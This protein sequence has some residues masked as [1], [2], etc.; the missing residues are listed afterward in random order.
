[1][2]DLCGREIDYVRVSITDRCNL[3]CV[4]CMPEK[5]VDAMRHGDMLT[6]EEIVR[7]VRSLASLGI[8]HVRVTGGEP[9]A[10]QGCLDLVERIHA[11]PGIEN[12]SMTTNGL[13]LSGRVAWA[14]EAGLDALNI[15]LDTLDPDA[16]RRITRGGDVTQVVHTMDEALSLGM[17]V[18]VNAVPVRGLNEDGLTALAALAREHPIQVRFIELM[19]LGCGAALEPIPSDEIVAMMTSAFGPMQPDTQRHGFGPAQ[20]FQ[21]EGFVG[22]IG[23]ISPMSHAFCGQCNRIRLT[24]DGFMKLCLNHTSG[25]DVRALLRGGADDH[26]LR[27]ALREAILHK[28]LRHGF[29]EAIGDRE[30]RRMNQIGG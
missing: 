2:R 23:V 10:R 29:T 18:K 19:P 24:A 4:Y 17:R 16:Y 1:M 28:P 6:Y 30:S 9:M 13:M 26:T 27:S 22:S 5:G 12:V 15:S 20:Y 11:I 3:R 7:T 14:R 8:R 25:L 21:P